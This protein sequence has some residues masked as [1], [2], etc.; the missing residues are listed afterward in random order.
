MDFFYWGAIPFFKIL[1]GV[2]SPYL[3][4]VTQDWEYHGVKNLGCS[5]RIKF[6]KNCPL[7]NTSSSS[8][9]SSSS[10]GGGGGGGGGGSSSADGGD[11]DH[12][13]Y[14]DDDDDNIATDDDEEEEEDELRTDLN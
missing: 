12:D 5:I 3:A 2:H 13:D 14:D 6:V 11:H 4:V 10:G 8:S 1:L 7:P 9:S